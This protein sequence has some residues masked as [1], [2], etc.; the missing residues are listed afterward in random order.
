MAA[1]AFA[2]GAVRTEEESESSM[3]VVGEVGGGAW[4]V[5]SQAGV[6]AGSEGLGATTGPQSVSGGTHPGFHRARTTDS[7]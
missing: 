7:S 4:R 5:G 3:V 2:A 6:P 1:E